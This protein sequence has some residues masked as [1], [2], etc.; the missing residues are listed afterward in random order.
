MGVANSF[1]LRL[2][3]VTE[4]T[5][6]PAGGA[7]ERQNGRLTGLLQEAL[8]QGLEAGGKLLL[9]QGITSVMDAGV[10]IRQGLEDHDA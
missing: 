9:S 6:Q 1:A 4:R 2:A 5:P 3:G 10:G 8:I 7:M